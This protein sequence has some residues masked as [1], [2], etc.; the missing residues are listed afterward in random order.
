M[1]GAV[2]RSSRQQQRSGVGLSRE[3]LAQLLPA[4]E[5]GINWH[6]IHS[7]NV[8]KLLTFMVGA[9]GIEPTT[10]TV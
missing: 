5:F 4:V 1:V 9:A 3:E 8:A 7:A 10:S 2:S 6:Q